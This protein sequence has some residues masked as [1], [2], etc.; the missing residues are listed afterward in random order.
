[1]IFIYRWPGITAVSALAIYT[2]LLVAL[3]KLLGITLTLSGIAGLILSIG[4]AVDANVLIFERIREELLLGKKKSLA[5]AE[6]FRRAWPSIRDGNV[7]TIITCF[8][9]IFLGTGMVRGFATA[10]VIG[11]M[12][13]MFT[14]IIITRAII[15][16]FLDERDK[17]GW[18]W[19]AREIK[20]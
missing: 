5:V 11:V 17:A 14:A 10:L 12:L 7:S 4:I 9:L 16:F 18:W 19:G 13:S 1:M 8:V 2:F 6:G 15:D 20:N 3:F